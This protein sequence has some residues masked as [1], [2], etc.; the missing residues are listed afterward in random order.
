MKLPPRKPARRRRPPLTRLQKLAIATGPKRPDLTRPQKIAFIAGPLILVPI[1]IVGVITENADEA[2]VAA[3]TVREA[4]ASSSAPASAPPSAVDPVESADPE[5]SPT[6]SQSEVDE[7][8]TREYDENNLQFGQTGHYL[9]G[10]GKSYPEVPLEFTVSAP[11]TFKPSKRAKF[12]DVFGFPY[13]GEGPHQPANVYF[14]V[15]LTNTSK[16]ETYDVFVQASVSESGD[17]EEQSYVEDGDVGKIWDL[18]EGD[19][20]GPGESVTVKDGWSLKNADDVRYELRIGGV[21][22]ESFYFTR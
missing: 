22:G 21:G 8:E 17:D 11:T 9:H 7:E 14:T 2:K 5:P 20:L 3:T 4:P 10:S 6:P 13:G 19:D 1:L 18:G 15:T 16:A 12:E